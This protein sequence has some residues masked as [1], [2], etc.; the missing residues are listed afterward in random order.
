MA[1]IAK[2]RLN[3]PL[4]HSKP[5]ASGGMND[6]QNIQVLCKDCHMMKCKGEQENHEYVKVCETASSLSQQVFDTKTDRL[7]K[8]FSFVEE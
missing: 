5:L 4:D 7:A 1:V 6:D 3:L 2:S 8:V